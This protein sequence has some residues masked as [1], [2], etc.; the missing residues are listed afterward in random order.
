MIVIDDQ[1]IPSTTPHTSTALINVCLYLFFPKST[2]S[3]V[4]L[5]SE[6]NESVVVIDDQHHSFDDSTYL[7]SMNPNPFHVLYS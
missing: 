4:L 5:V 7:S 3:N 6:L 2:L 1:H